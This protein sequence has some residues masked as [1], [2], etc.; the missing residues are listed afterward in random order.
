MFGNKARDQAGRLRL[1]DEIRKEGGGRA[2]AA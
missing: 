1:F 2:I